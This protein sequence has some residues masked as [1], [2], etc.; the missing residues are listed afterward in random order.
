MTNCRWGAAA[1]VASE[2]MWLLTNTVRHYPWGSRTVIP[3]LL[4]EA[5]PGEQPCAELWLGAHPDG[6]SVL[7]DG[8]PLDK[9][10]AQR[11]AALLGESARQ[12]FGDRLPFLMK[13]LA[14]DRPLSL[15]AHPTSAQ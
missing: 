4:G 13:V 8:T 5:S 14:A 12:R 2:P 11:P 10:I 9:A 7:D 1:R 3:A 6:P 15:Q